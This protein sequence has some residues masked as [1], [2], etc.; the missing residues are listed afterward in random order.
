MQQEKD[1][2]NHDVVIQI[3]PGNPCTFVSL[4]QWTG[5]PTHIFECQN[6]RYLEKL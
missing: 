4:Q 5:S 6:E 3:F 2:A 1:L